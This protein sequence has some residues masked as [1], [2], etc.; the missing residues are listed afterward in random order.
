MEQLVLRAFLAGDRLDVVEQQCTRVAIACA[1]LLHRPFPQ[2]G[3]EL[4]RERGGGDA[5]DGLHTVGNH[6]V[7]DG[8]QQ[9]RAPT[10]CR[11]RDDERNE[12]RAGCL[13]HC[14]GGAQRELIR[15]P[16]MQRVEQEARLRTWRRLDGRDGLLHQ[17]VRLLDALR[18]TKDGV[19]GQPGVSGRTLPLEVAQ[20]F[21]R[22]AKGGQQSLDVRRLTQL[23]R[24]LEH[25]DA[26][27]LRA[28]ARRGIGQPH[29]PLLDLFDHRGRD[30]LHERVVVGG[31]PAARIVGKVRRCRERRRASADETSHIG[32]ADGRVAHALMCEQPIQ[33]TLQLA[34]VRE[35]DAREL[36]EH[37]IAEAQHPFAL[38]LLQNRHACLVIR[39][40]DIDDQ[41]S[42]EPREQAVGD[43]GD[44]VRR[45]VARH[46]D[47]RAAALQHV[48][49][50]QQLG[51][52]LG[53]S[54][55]ELHVVQQQHAGGLVAL[56][57]GVEATALQR[58]MK[59]LHVVVQRHV[60]DGQRRLLVPC[61]M[62]DCV[63]QV[64]LAEAGC[65]VHEQRVVQH[66]RR[67]GNRFCS[68]DSEA[69]GR[70]GDEGI[71]AEA[72]IE[73]HV[74]AVSGQRRL[75]YRIGHVVPRARRGWHDTATATRRVTISRG[76][77]RGAAW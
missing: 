21:H 28:P 45:T 51:L 71:E 57:E 61:R 38:Q 75:S 18:V 69:I 2:R 31:T 73:F 10:A 54:R 53:A 19:P 3:D 41:A 50:P 66:A 23:Q 49:E 14:A 20:V 62:P 7:A 37:A 15:E 27:T 34:D 25:R 55:E 72:V 32:D 6:R 76:F 74:S 17:R 1:P 36:L 8:V 52:D 30:F 44:F 63:H 9:V 26:D 64:R 22:R 42:G 33:P 13:D 35:I 59:L 46:H 65:A 47:L 5:G 56:L 39:D 67:I 58:L 29:P 68:G 70:A 40:A 77:P 24:A 12:L 48:E 43:V 60:L 11:S 16:F 4:L